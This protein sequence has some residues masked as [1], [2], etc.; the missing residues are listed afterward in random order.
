MSRQYFLI[1]SS[2]FPLPFHLFLHKNQVLCCPDGMHIVAYGYILSFLL[3]SSK[4]LNER[5]TM[6]PLVARLLWTFLYKSTITEL[7]EFGTLRNTFTSNGG[8][9]NVDSYGS[10]YTSLSFQ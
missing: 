8:R 2:K 10:N 9:S 6:K 5:T 7:W 3:L 4:P 1:Q